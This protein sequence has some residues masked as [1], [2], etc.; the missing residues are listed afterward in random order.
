MLDIYKLDIT[1]ALSKITTAQQKL[2]FKREIA[3]H[4]VENEEN[5]LESDDTSFAEHLEM[6]KYHIENDGTTNNS[7][8]TT[9]LLINTKVNQKIKGIQSTNFE[10]LKTKVEK[11]T[12]IKINLDLQ[13]RTFL[14]G[15]IIT[16]LNM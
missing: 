11:N 13:L 2:D 15:S 14:K 6:E 7:S 9:N 1:K 16:N 10:R 5:D 3:D 4:L 8:S 12:K